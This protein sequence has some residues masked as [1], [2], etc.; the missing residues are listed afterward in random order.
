MG[1]IRGY[2]VRRM[3]IRKN[4]QAGRDLPRSEGRARVRRCNAGRDP[5]ATIADG[6]NAQ[7]C[8]V[9]SVTLGA[10]QAISD[11][12]WPKAGAVSFKRQVGRRRRI[13]DFIGHK[14][15]LSEAV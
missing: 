5:L 10:R 11:G 15:V 14:F 3:R 6:T 8:G 7:I 4:W 9:I 2:I 13:G 1:G 12:L